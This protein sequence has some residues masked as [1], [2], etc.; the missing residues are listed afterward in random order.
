M[1][2]IFQLIRKRKNGFR[3]LGLIHYL[4][5]RKGLECIWLEDSRTMFFELFLE[6]QESVV[7]ETL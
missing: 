3:Y 5:F 6:I 2:P 4:W 1:I 7:L